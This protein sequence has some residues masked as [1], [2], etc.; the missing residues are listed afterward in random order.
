GMDLSWM[1][2]GNENMLSRITIEARKEHEIWTSPEQM[3]KDPGKARL[4]ALRI[5]LP[6]Y[7]YDQKYLP[8]IQEAL[9]KPEYTSFEVNNLIW[10]N[11]SQ[12]NYD[13]KNSFKDLQ[14][15]TLILAGRQDILGEAVP[16]TI[17]Q[18]IPGS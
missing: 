10:K 2:Y 11:L 8:V 13:L 3:A 17:H 6:A 12:T 5:I 14:V 4:E 15:S 16:I 7:L 9:L 18:A 1:E